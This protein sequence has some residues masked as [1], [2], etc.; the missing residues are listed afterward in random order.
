MSD[1]TKELTKVAIAEEITEGTYAAPTNDTFLETTEDGVSIEHSKDEKTR[2]NMSGSRIK[3]DLRLSRSNVS[4]TIPLELRTGEAV[5]KAPNYNPLIE[6]AGFEATEVS[7]RIATGT[8]HTTTKI[9]LSDTSD[10]E[11]GDCIVLKEYDLNPL[12]A[13]I[14]NVV[15]AIVADTSIDLLV[16]SATTPSDNVEIEKFTRDKQRD[17]KADGVT[18]TG[19]TISVTRAFEGDELVEKAIG[20]RVTGFELNFAADEIPT[21]NFT[22]EGLSHQEDAETFEA[23]PGVPFVPAYD[24]AE[25]APVLKGGLYKDTTELCITE[26]SLSL[27]S[28]IAFKTCIGNKNKLASRGVGKQTTSGSANPYKDGSTEGISLDNTTWQLFLFNADYGDADCK[29]ITS[30]TGIYVPK[31]K[32]VTKTIEDADG[33]VIENVGWKMVA[34]SED[35]GITICFS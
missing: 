10:L 17:I 8:S 25:P 26:A 13:D 5:G 24:D 12:I 22:L 7:A 15:T 28:G 31:V 19:N 3:Q 23:S 4:A 6:S 27:E 20:M 1:I 11:V 33:L 18:P 35:E 16:V 29:E 2:A 34:D 14:P 30:F 21:I 32:T 9:F